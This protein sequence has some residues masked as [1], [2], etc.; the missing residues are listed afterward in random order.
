MIQI[1]LFSPQWQRRFQRYTRLK[2]KLSA[3]EQVPA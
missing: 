3:L 2:W 1:T